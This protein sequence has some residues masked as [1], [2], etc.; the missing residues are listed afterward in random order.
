M[1]GGGTGM[2]N[3]GLPRTR[4]QQLRRNATP[5]EN[6][7]WY[8]FLKTYP[9]QFR[10]QAPFGQYIVDFYCAGAR[11]AVE[12][13]GSQHYEGAGPE[14]DRERTEYLKKNWDILV[15]RFT[16]LEVRRNFEGVCTA[17][18]RE[19]RRRVPSSVS[20][21]EPASP[22]EGGSQRDG[23][24]PPTGGKVARRAG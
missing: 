6:H 17:I 23:S 22:P 8:D 14:H 11:L 3:D 5:E 1:R 18:D 13:D 21:R 10:R 15:I 20:L 4:A 2:E 12:L 7:L 19:V 24:L 16:N 9:L